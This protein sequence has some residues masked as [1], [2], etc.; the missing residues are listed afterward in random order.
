MKPSDKEQKLQL[1]AQLYCW[2]QSIQ[3]KPAPAWAHTAA[4]D[5]YGRGADKL[6]AKL[7][8]EMKRLKD[9]IPPHSGSLGDIMRFGQLTAWWAEHQLAD[10][11]RAREVHAKRKRDAVKAEALAKLSPT[12]QKVLGLS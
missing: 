9:V 5:I 6:V 8:G 2:L 1:T 3:Q 10:K 11:A 7:C 12:D 4:G